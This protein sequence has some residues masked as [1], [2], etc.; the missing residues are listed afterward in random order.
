M[1]AGP[2]DRGPYEIGGRTFKTKEELVKHG[3]GVMQRWRTRPRVSITGEDEAF[4][5]DLSRR[6][7]ESLIES[8]GEIE[9]FFVELKEEFGYQPGF[10]VRWKDGTEEHW[11]YKKAIYPQTRHQQIKDA[12]HWAINPQVIE[13]KGWAKDRAG[14]LM[15]CPK[16]QKTLITDGAEL[17]HYPLC[18]KDILEGFL[19]WE[20]SSL[21]AVA[22]VDA[23]KYGRRLADEDLER[24]WQSYHLQHARY[25]LLCRDCN[26]QSWREY[27]SPPTNGDGL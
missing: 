1:S 14:E 15:V 27:P 9:S 25:R 24:R 5:R 20:R 17:D 18:F 12:F 6:R 21:D 22:L 2:R 3:Q 13:A 4:L 23:V 8:H 10:C 11:S 19:S 7:L 26:N 16:C